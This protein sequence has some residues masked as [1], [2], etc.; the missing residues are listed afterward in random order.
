MR[1]HWGLAMG[2]TYIHVSKF[3]ENGTPQNS[4]LQPTGDNTP[5]YQTDNQHGQVDIS[6]SD[7]E[8]LWTHLD[9]PVSDEDKSSDSDS[10]ILVGAMY[11]SDG[12]G[13]S[14]GD[15]GGGHDDFYEF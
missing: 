15:A 1:Y 12:N 13:D 7:D 3:A 2:H 8:E 11:E 9:E 14:C 6:D 10:I 4:G 5:D